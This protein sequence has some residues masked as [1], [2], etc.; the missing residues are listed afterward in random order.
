MVTNPPKVSVCIPTYNH[1]HFLKDAV[2][3]VLAQTCED[4]ELIVVDNCSTDNTRGLV[5]GYASSDC[6]IAYFCNETNVGPQEN[7]NRCLKH[8]SGEY[9]KILCA[10]DLLEPT[11]LAESVRAL[12]AGPGVVLAA[13]ARLLVDEQLRPLRVAGYSDRNQVVSGRDMINY[14]LFNGN[15]IGEPSAVLFRRNAARRGFD[16]SCSLLI[17]AEMWLHILENGNMAYIGEPLCR[18]RYHGAQETNKVIASLAFIDEEMRLYEKYIRM[19]YVDASLLNRI[20]RKFKLAWMLPLRDSA[21]I[22]AGRLLEKVRSHEGY[23]LLYVVF[24]G[25]LAAG[26]IAGMFNRDSSDQLR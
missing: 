2:E 26:R 20:K 21:R 7:L 3:S 19:E 9:V 4:F 13:T 12:E 5:A 1:A 24:V 14:T 23:G 25:R 15:Y 16:T 10:D 17:D 8:A 11:C 6:R 18:F 22:D